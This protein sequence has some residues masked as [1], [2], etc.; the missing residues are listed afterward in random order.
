MENVMNTGLRTV[1]PTESK[2]ITPL[3][4]WILSRLLIAT[5]TLMFVPFALYL[6]QTS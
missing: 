5:S 4:V 2:E 1:H 3:G 6:W